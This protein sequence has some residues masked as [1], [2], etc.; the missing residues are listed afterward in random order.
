MILNNHMVLGNVK[1]NINNY[2]QFTE[3]IIILIDHLHIPDLILKLYAF[4]PFFFYSYLPY[5]RQ[6]VPCLARAMKRTMNLSIIYIDL[7]FVDI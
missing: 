5:D 3:I 1:N 2:I 6:M 7:L 4:I